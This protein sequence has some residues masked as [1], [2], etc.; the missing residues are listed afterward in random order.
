MNNSGFYVDKRIPIAVIIT[1]VAQLMAIVWGAS[2]LYSSVE[3]NS[4]QINRLDGALSGDGNYLLR[5]IT[6]KLKQAD[7]KLVQN[8][9]YYDNRINTL[10]QSY[11]SIERKLILQIEINDD[12]RKKQKDIIED[13]T[14]EISNLRK[15][16]K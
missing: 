6:R 11:S 2:S 8:K 3:N 9:E 1:L 16:I 14:K 15:L 5:D 12:F 4:I 13:L 10:R 7:T